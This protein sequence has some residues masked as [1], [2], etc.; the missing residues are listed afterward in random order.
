MRLYLRNPRALVAAGLTPLVLLVLIAAISDHRAEPGYDEWLAASMATL[1]LASM[2]YTTLAA[3]LVASRDAG[4]LKRL[5]A[6]PLPLS[7]HLAGRVLATVAVTLGQAVV[8]FAVAR[9][10]YGATVP[11]AWTAWVGLLAG[12]VALCAIGL[13]VAQVVPRGD[14][15]A[16]LLSSTLLPVVLVSGVFFPVDRLPG[17]V[18]RVAE[19]S[20]LTHIGALL[21]G[22]PRWSHFAWLLGWTAVAFAFARWRFQLEPGLRRFSA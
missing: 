16:T 8:L 22:D 9:L 5:F 7:V 15:A 19:F 11:V 2:C 21:G 17:G 1:G 3:S 18:A 20:P 4:V 6:T 10:A 12:A 13:A 14:A